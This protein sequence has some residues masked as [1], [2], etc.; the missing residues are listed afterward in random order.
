MQSVIR[1]LLLTSLLASCES[2]TDPASKAPVASPSPPTAQQDLA[3]ATA[4]ESPVA[5]FKTN[6]GERTVALEVVS[7]PATIQ[8]GLMHR[9][10]LPPDAGMLFIFGSDRVRSFWMKNTLIP[11][12]MLFIRADNSVAGIE[13]ETTPL[14][15]DS[16]SVGIP[17]RY[18]LEL[19]G[20]WTAKYGI[21]PGAIV[22]FEHLPPVS[23][24]PL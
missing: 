8:R 16:R 2:S 4:N 6:A 9:E 14:S 24:P 18:V 17:T 22:R 7:N 1:G 19:N 3:P 11:L 12:D 15:L 10:H 20:G 13:R 23:N 5:I 21:E